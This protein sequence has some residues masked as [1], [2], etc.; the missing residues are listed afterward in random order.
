MFSVIVFIFI[1]FKNVADSDKTGTYWQV[2]EFDERT[3]ALNMVIE[4]EAD[5][6]GKYLIDL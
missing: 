2:V 5:T 3:R 1:G 4:E 6:G